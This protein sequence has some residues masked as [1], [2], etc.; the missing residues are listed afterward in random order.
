MGIPL[1]GITVEVVGDIDLC[2]FFA[3]SE[4]ARPGYSHIATEVTLDSP[5]SDEDLQRLT[6]A[7]HEHCPVL[8]IIKNA[9]P[10]SFSI[11]RKDIRSA[12]A[13]AL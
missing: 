11:R 2:G 4:E 8:D 10:V 7:V 9:T 5:A 1:D 6:Q 13:H 12:A 3:A